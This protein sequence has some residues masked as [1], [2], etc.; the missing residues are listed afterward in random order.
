MKSFIDNHK[1]L[2][3][4]FSNNNTLIVNEIFELETNDQHK[5]YWMQN[6]AILRQSNHYLK[7][8]AVVKNLYT[9]STRIGQSLAKSERNQNF[10]SWIM[11]GFNSVKAYS[12]ELIWKT[13]SEIDCVK[14]KK[15]WARVLRVLQKSISKYFEKPHSDTKQCGYKSTLTNEL[16]KLASSLNIQDCYK[17]KATPNK[18]TKLVNSDESD[19]EQSILDS[20][21]ETP[22]KCVSSFSGS[23]AST[24]WATSPILKSILRKMPGKC[25]PR[26]ILFTDDWETKNHQPTNQKPE[27]N[28]ILLKSNNDHPNAL[29]DE[30]LA[31]QNKIHDASVIETNTNE[32]LNKESPSSKNCQIRI[33]SNSDDA[34][35]VRTSETIYT[36]RSN[37]NSKKSSK[38]KRN[39]TTR[40]KLKEDKRLFGARIKICEENNEVKEFFKRRMIKSDFK[41]NPRFDVAKKR[42]KKQTQKDTEASTFVMPETSGI[43]KPNPFNYK[44]W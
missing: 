7:H 5:N 19:Q 4:K 33:N 43:L 37:Q 22:H 2:K 15:I 18:L 40:F 36:D 6:M 24:R 38:N 20:T 10:Y 11:E 16:E 14:Q 23:S 39:Y 44:F 8:E 21:M 42:I 9:V 32:I 27:W 12:D 28:E 25:S 26:K 29:I 30:N 13:M 17:I 31:N 1:D 3:M 41:F 34:E 35:S